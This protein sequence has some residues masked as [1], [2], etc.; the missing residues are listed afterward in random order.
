MFA[1]LLLIS[2]LG[3]SALAGSGDANSIVGFSA[4]GAAEEVYVEQQFRS[5]TSTDQ[6]SKFHRYLTSEPHPAGSARNNELA[7]WVA[8]Q[9]RQQGLEDVTI[10]EYDVL[11][12]SPREISLE[13]VHP[14][15]FH[16]SLREDPYDVDP[17]SYTHLDVYKRQAYQQRRAK[18][19][20]PGAH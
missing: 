3:F 4:R 19:A 7:Q 2:P 16:A 20:L 5:L 11:N 12:S 14:G 18:E 10:H 13:M 17:V 1:A 8:E 15:H 9:W 6:I